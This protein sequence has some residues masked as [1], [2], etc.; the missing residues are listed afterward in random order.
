[1][2]ASDADA[3]EGWESDRIEGSYL[4]CVERGACVSGEP[5]ARGAG[6]CAQALLSVEPRILPDHV[7]LAVMLATTEVFAGRRFR[8]EMREGG[9]QVMR[10][11]ALFL[12]C[13][14]WPVPVG[15]GSLARFAKRNEISPQ[16]LPRALTAVDPDAEIGIWVERQLPAGVVRLLG[17]VTRDGDGRIG[18]FG[19]AYLEVVPAPRMYEGDVP[20]NE[21]DPL[22]GVA[23]EL[24]WWY[25]RCILGR[26]AKGLGRPAGPRPDFEEREGRA[27]WEAVVELRRA[28]RKVTMTA[29]A[30]EMSGLL[31][32]E[33][34]RT[35]LQY[36]VKQ[37]W[38]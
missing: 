5:K 21:R 12:L 19:E 24:G 36:W 30:T 15:E 16:S 7:C 27:Y 28:R 13:R 18:R 37:G 3:T 32:Y 9:K 29:I 17:P 11:M 22:R 4:C 10:D 33:V 20:A 23:R 6:S 35:T 26:A 25:Q 2:T 31:G 34:G 14:A 8:R 1:M 38:V